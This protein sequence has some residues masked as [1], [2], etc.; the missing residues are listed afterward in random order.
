[1]FYVRYVR[2]IPLVRVGV[3]NRLSINVTTLWRKL[4][5]PRQR[6]THSNIECAFNISKKQIHLV[7]TLIE[8]HFLRNKVNHTRIKITK[9]Q[10][11]IICLQSP[12]SKDR[13]AGRQTDIQTFRQIQP[14]NLRFQRFN[15]F[16]SRFTYFGKICFRYFVFFIKSSLK[17]IVDVKDH[18]L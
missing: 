6:K 7:E 18:V 4:I 11:S 16:V 13:Q 1:M 17:E 9:K 8:I 14:I 15:M 3:E 5:A 12:I 2:R 10:E